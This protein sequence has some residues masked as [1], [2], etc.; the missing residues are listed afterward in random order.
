MGKQYAL[1]EIEFWDHAECQ[2]VSDPCRC[3]VWGPVWRETKL[4][5]QIVSWCMGSDVRDFNSKTYTILKST[6]IGKPYVFGYTE[7]L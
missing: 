7:S 5:Y 6:I 4:C 1:V 3:K 2:G